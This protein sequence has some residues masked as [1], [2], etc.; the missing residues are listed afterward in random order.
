[1][2][3]ALTTRHNTL[4]RRVSA[5]RAVRQVLETWKQRHD[6]AQL[7]DH[8]LEDIGVT[9]QEASTEIERSIWDVPGHWIK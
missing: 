6:L 1:M 4:I 8:L 7:D 5:L 9:R 3:T 2:N